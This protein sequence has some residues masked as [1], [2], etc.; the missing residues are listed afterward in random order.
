MSLWWPGWHT[1]GLGG[2]LFQAGFPRPRAG[3]HG[4]IVGRH[5]DGSRGC[6]ENGLRLVLRGPG[7][8]RRLAGVRLFPAGACR[9]G[10]LLLDWAFQPRCPQVLLLLHC[11]GLRRGHALDPVGGGLSREHLQQA[12]VAAVRIRLTAGAAAGPWGWSGDEHVSA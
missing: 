4:R 9:E 3:S 2:K 1:L 7:A 8:R 10:W 12:L 5:Q 11:L 6:M